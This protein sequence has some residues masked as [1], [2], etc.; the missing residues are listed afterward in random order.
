MTYVTGPTIV[1]DL[2]VIIRAVEKGFVKNL[3]FR[4]L[5]KKILKTSKVQIL[6]S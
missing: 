3:G 6:S 1:I 4:F 5:R 2:P